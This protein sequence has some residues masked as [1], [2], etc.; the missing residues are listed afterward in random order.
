M[1]SIAGNIVQLTHVDA[2][3][4]LKVEQPVLIQMLT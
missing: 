4:S 2:A 1:V 3:D